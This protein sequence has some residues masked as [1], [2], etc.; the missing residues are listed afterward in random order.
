VAACD[1]Q[2]PFSLPLFERGEH[3]A[4]VPESGAYCVRQTL[5]RRGQLKPV[6]VAPEQAEA[7]F[8]FHGGD[9]TTDRRSG[10]A[11]FGTRRSEILMPGG[12][13]EHDE[14]ID[15]GQGPSQGHHIKIITYQSKI[16]SLWQTI[17]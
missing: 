5:P 6:S 3:I 15:G 7:G 4:H 14:R 1:G 17:F 2:R 8:A 13:F 11:E 12:H 10:D 16:S 9:V